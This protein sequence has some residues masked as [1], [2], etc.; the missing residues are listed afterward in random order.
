M[1]AS[2]FVISAL[3]SRQ[4]RI[5]VAGLVG[6][7]R[8]VVSHKLASASPCRDAGAGIAMEDTHAAQ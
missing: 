8:L 6:H 2:A 7:R 5:L 1:E 3:A 4:A